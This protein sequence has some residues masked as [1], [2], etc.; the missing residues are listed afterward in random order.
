MVHG[1]PSD[2]KIHDGDIVSVDVGIKYN[3]WVGDAAR[4]FLIGD[5]SPRTKQLSEDTHKALWAGIEKMV[6]GNRLYDIN[7]AI[8]RVSIHGYA[9]LKNFSG[10]GVGRNLHEDPVVFNY[11]NRNQPNVRLRAG[12]VLAIEP[13]FV[14]GTGDVKVLEDGWTVVTTDNSLA[15][16]WELSVAITENEP[17]IL[18]R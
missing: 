17:M 16:H 4:T 5:V 15:A 18:G 2:R 6:P 10:H 1:I 14:L 12:M 8:Y 13:M 11:I 7:D 3:G 9:T